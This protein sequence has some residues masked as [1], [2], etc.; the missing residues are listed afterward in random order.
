MFNDHR[1]RLL[2]IMARFEQQIPEAE[3]LAVCKTMRTIRES[4]QL[5]ACDARWPRLSKNYF[6]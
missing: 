5:M 2:R 4:E 6:W 3:G 1:T